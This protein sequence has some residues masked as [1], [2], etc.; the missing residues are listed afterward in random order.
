MMMKKE[1]DEDEEERRRREKKIYKGR[2]E[3]REANK[4]QEP[5]RSRTRR[6]AINQAIN[7]AREID[8]IQADG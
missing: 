1:E 8:S 2:R 6:Q 3:I 4:Q 5:A 7:Q